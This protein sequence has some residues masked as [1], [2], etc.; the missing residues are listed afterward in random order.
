VKSFGV[1]AMPQHRNEALP[2]PFCSGFTQVTIRAKKY[3]P[4]DGINLAMP[5]ARSHASHRVLN[6]PAAQTSVQ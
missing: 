5:T 6:I 2:V 4:L 1:A 3:L